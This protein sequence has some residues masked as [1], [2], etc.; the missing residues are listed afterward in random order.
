[1]RIALIALCLEHRSRLCPDHA[2]TNQ[3]IAEHHRTTVIPE[4]KEAQPL[5]TKWGGAPR[6][7]RKENAARDAVGSR[8]LVE[9]DQIAASR[10]GD[11][12]ACSVTPSAGPAGCCG[13]FCTAQLLDCISNRHETA[14]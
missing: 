5:D 12:R 7:A 3:G 8:R 10:G 14:L 11:V 4:Q 1:M 2:A 6:P 13:R 9:A